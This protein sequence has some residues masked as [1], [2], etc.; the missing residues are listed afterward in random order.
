MH[1]KTIDIKKIKK[2]ID[3]QSWL[4]WLLKLTVLWAMSFI[5]LVSFFISDIFYYF[6]YLEIFP[7]EL[8]FPLLMHA[9]TALIMALVVLL[10]PKPKTISAKLVVTI[11]ISLFLIDYD[12]RLQAVT[13]IYRAAF[14]VLPK[15]NNEAPFIS[16]L[17]LM[18]ILGMSIAIGRYIEY[19]QVKNKR[20]H[21]QN[22]IYSLLIMFGVVFISQC[23]K[24]VPV[25]RSVN[26]EFNIKINQYSN[27]KVDKNTP[28]SR[29]DIYYIVLDRYASNNV[30][31]SDFNFDNS[32]FSDYLKTSGF[33]INESAY[34]N[35]PLTTMSI[36]ST[37]NAG[38][39]DEYTK[40][41]IDKEVQSRTLFHALIQRSSVIT[42]LKTA[43][44]KYYH[45]GS[46]YGASYDAPLADGDFMANTSRN[47]EIFRYKTNLKGI[48]NIQFMKSPYYRF[49]HI[50][51]SWWPIKTWAA[52]GYEYIRE[53]L[54]SLDWIT[55]EQPTG[56]R[57]VFVHILMPHEPYHFNADGS[58]NINP[59]SDNWG[60]TIKQKYINQLQFVN[61]QIEM[62]IDKI[63][64]NDNQ[65]VI[66]L[67]S[68][69]GPYPHILN[70]TTTKPIVNDKIFEKK[71]M[72]QWPDSWLKMKYSILQAV[73]IPA[74]SQT[75]MDN[76]SSVNI[77]RIILNNYLK[78]NL[79]YLPNCNYALR[80]GNLY[81]YDF[82][83]ITSRLGQTDS[84]RCN[85]NL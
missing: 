27:D 46:N 9:L 58:L 59:G 17:F 74:A 81:E 32:E 68:D 48:E 6:N 72:R 36:A 55:N 33:I 10:L 52:R 66:I 26:S 34:S 82:T 44:Y 76:L 45:I 37:I 38:Y 84:P 69:E 63:I 5:I 67:N 78:Y 1:F 35:Y 41:F 75:D 60:T 80:R 22:I 43:G 77:F 57:F 20:L 15:E 29:P 42:A 47:L 50:Y 28:T 2:F 16:L 7:H 30:L 39:L 18:T 25:M 51:T 21:P 64:K 4:R 19:L 14:P 54:E 61:A 3:R 71:D 49:A 13:G 40:P 83:N 56:G 12:S 62:Q 65:A 85:I 24:L 31:K 73:R 53:Q 70:S 8:R 79:E 11:I 23:W